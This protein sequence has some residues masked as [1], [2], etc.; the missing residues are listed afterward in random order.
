[1]F[2]RL[3]V[4]LSVAGPAWAATPGPGFLRPSDSALR[5]GTQGPWLITLPA[6][7]PA[8]AAPSPAGGSSF[9]DLM[10]D[11]RHGHHLS[12]FHLLDEAT[13]PVGTGA[14]PA[15]K[16]PSPSAGGDSSEQ[17]ADGSSLKKRIYDIGSGSPDEAVPSPV[18]TAAPPV[19]TAAPVVAAGGPSPAGGRHETYQGGCHETYFPD[20]IWSRI[21]EYN[22]IARRAAR[23]RS[24]FADVMS[25]IKFGRHLSSLH[26]LDRF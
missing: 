7:G 15:T 4:A 25:D 20:A 18:P 3:V 9:A 10:N 8:T 19:P 6:G 11:I 23:P 16:R 14:A 12:S 21:K 2:S 26:D 24:S 17:P 13:S 5:P 1:M 22:L